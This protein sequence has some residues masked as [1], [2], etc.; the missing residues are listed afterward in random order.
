MLKDMQLHF[1][2][3]EMQIRM[4]TSHLP[5]WKNYKYMDIKVLGPEQLK[6]VQPP[7]RT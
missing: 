2:I 5:N 6:R 4:I 7:K 1:Q 3:R